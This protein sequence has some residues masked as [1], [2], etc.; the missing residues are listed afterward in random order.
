MHLLKEEEE[1][2]KLHK[3]YVIFLL[4]VPESDG[5]REEGVL[6]C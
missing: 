4:T 6:I 3:L 1:L 5:A 2:G